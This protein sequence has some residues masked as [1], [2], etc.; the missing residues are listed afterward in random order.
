MDTTSTDPYRSGAALL[1]ISKPLRYL[2][3]EFSSVWFGWCWYGLVGL[4]WFGYEF[5]MVQYRMAI[6]VWLWPNWFGLVWY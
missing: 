1:D 6:F 2:V 5:G 3:V 4:V